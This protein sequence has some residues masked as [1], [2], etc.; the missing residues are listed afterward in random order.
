M[1]RKDL[2]EDQK[3]LDDSVGI[4]LWY[5][6]KNLNPYEVAEYLR[7]MADEAQQYGDDEMTDEE[8]E[9]RDKADGV[10]VEDDEGR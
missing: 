2:S 3:R 8:V 5:G 4:L 9:A 10:W 6:I 1:K 7:A